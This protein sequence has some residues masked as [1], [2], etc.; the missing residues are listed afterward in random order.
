MAGATL[1]A[2][3]NN[4]DELLLL[5][6]GGEQDEAMGHVDGVLADQGYERE[7]TAPDGVVAVYGRGSSG[8]RILL[9]GFSGRQEFRVTEDT[10]GDLVLITIAGTASILTAGALGVSKMRKELARLNECMAAELGAAPDAPAVADEELG[11]FA[12]RMK[13]GKVKSRAGEY[14]LIIIVTLAAAAVGAVVAFTFI[15]GR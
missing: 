12:D 2:R 6:R 7:A 11:L 1:I 13:S 9:G 3:C 10:D 5:F 4:K 8:A 15:A 14:T